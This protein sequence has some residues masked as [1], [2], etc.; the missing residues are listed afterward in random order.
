[1]INLGHAFDD[2]SCARAI[3]IDAPDDDAT[4]LAK[5][6]DAAIENG[7]QIISAPMSETE[8]LWPWLESS[9]IKIFN[10]F[11]FM[12]DK[13]SVDGMSGL[14]VTVM[15]AFRNGAAGAQ[16]FVSRKNIKD[17]IEMILPIRNDLF[18]N[19][20]LIVGL[21]LDDAQGPYWAA[22]F[23]EI[24]KIEPDAVLLTAQGDVFDAKSDFVGR[25][26][27][28]LMNWDLNCDLHIM[29]GKNMFRVCQTLR[30]AQKIRP[31][32]VEKMHVFV[33]PDFIMK[34]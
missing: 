14:A 31:N 27:D 21:N 13:N 18:F 11:D 22:T 34:E 24:K 19:H 8:K 2:V 30:L 1:M 16:I 29:F 5:I 6:A 15:S 25:V 3:W 10:R 12:A 26:Y 4:D 20:K 17:F 33:P 23:D 28:M 7:V 32:L 9:D